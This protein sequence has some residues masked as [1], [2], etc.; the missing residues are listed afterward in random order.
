MWTR[1]FVFGIQIWYFY[2]KIPDYIAQ[3][4][5]TLDNLEHQRQEILGKKQY[6]ELNRIVAEHEKYAKY[7]PLVQHNKQLERE[8]HGT[9]NPKNTTKTL[10]KNLDRRSQ[11]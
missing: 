11:Y 2:R 8:L 10:V 1:S 5:K 7:I 3:V 9:K 6:A 4:K